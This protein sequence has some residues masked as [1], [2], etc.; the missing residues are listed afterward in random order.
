M[1]EK[2][3][4]LSEI[5]WLNKIKGVNTGRVFKSRRQLIFALG[6]VVLNNFNLL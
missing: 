3:R 2:R 6:R 1:R 4:E 5:G